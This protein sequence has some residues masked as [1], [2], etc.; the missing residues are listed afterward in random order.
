MY[1]RRRD[2]RPAINI[3]FMFFF[4]KDI[5]WKFKNYHK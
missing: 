5:D 3:I 2:P 1:G 4:I